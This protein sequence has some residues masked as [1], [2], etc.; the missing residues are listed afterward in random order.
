MTPNST[1]L[2]P[3]FFIDAIERPQPI[4]NSVT[5]SALCEATFIT[6]N[7]PSGNEI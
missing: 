2:K 3:T 7:N 6:S 5:E 1:G 4:R